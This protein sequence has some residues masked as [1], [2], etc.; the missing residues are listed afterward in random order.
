MIQ[1]DEIESYFVRLLLLT[2]MKAIDR[3]MMAFTYLSG[4]IMDY[5]IANN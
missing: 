3:E 2:W 5:C 4:D 1:D